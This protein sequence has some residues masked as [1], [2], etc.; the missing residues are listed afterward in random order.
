MKLKD[1][2]EVATYEGVEMHITNIGYGLK[3]RVKFS[4]V[5]EHVYASILVEDKVYLD[6]ANWNHIFNILQIKIKRAT[7]DGPISKLNS[8]EDGAIISKATEL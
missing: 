4:I 5:V 3:N 6:K 8:Y 2:N 1:I 7:I